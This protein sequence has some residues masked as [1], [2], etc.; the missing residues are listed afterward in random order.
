MTDR[1]ASRVEVNPISGGK[2]VTLVT[3]TTVVSGTDTVTLKLSDYGITSVL[4]VEEQVHTTDYS[5]IE[6]GVTSF[7]TTVTTGTLTVTLSNTG[8]AGANDNK[9]RFVVVY[10]V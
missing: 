3:G 8:G 5:V 6:D 4:G 7:A 9:R 1:T 2:I 10:G